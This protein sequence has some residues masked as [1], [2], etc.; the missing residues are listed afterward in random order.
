MAAVARPPSQPD[1]DAP[2]ATS[3]PSRSRVSRTEVD[4][5]SLHRGT[6]TKEEAS[7][8]ITAR[9]SGAQEAQPYTI[10]EA[11]AG[12][13]KSVD[14]RFALMQEAIADR[15][16]MEQIRATISEEL[17]NA[18][19]DRLKVTVQ[20]EIVNAI[21]DEVTRTVQQQVSEVVRRDVKSVVQHE[22]TNIVDEDIA[23][24]IQQHVTG[25]VKEQV[26]TIVQQQVTSIVQ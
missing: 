14:E 7:R 5:R 20:R 8:Q 9:S 21:R 22:V 3:H 2:S 4:Y 15:S 19:Q 12:V 25:I 10:L 18:V 23:A 6:L 1:D 11:V 17:S 26:T 16:D 24:I 13:R